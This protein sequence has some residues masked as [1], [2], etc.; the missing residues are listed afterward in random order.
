MTETTI[1]EPCPE[2]RGACQT[3]TW[4]LGDDPSFIAHREGCETC[5]EA[6]EEARALARRVGAVHAV[7]AEAARGLAQEVFARTTRREPEAS[8]R[9]WTWAG[10]GVGLAAAGAAFLTLRR[11]PAPMPGDALELAEVDPEL[12]QDL[13]LAEELELL[14]LLDALEAL[15]HV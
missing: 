10:I 1:R 2:H 8:R 15:D 6:F 9:P 12:L 14:E 5:R 13:E 7:P 3:A 4:G 11:P